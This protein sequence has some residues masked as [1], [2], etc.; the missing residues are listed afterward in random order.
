MAQA[1]FNWIV[2]NATAREAISDLSAS[3]VG[4]LAWQ[5][6]DN[7]VWILTSP[8][9]VWVN[10]AD[11]PT[12]GMAKLATVNGVNAKTVAATTLYTVPAKRILLPAEI[13]IRVLT[14]DGAGKTTQGKV[15]FGANSA[16]YDD[17]KSAADLTV[18]AVAKFQTVKASA[19]V[20][21][22]TEGKIF[23]ANISVGSDA[24]TETWGF[25]L[26][27]WLI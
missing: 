1:P 19:A 4:K 5:Q 7:T 3:D 21:Y 14:Y 23:K 24:T 9:G 12:F 17:Y 2:A 15:S 18:A 26:F 25:T 10:V 20:P 22:Y 16:D 6:S 8:A 13:Y 11:A 27:G